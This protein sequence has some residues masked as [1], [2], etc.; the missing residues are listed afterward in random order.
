M[1]YPPFDTVRASAR[2]LAR[3]GSLPR[4][5]TGAETRHSNGGQFPDARAAKER[6]DEIAPHAAPSLDCGLVKP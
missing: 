4:G 3:L 1:Q 6:V 5:G 2:L